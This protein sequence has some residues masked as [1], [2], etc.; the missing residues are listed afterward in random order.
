MLSMGYRRP[1]AT[2]SVTS[3]RPGE[4]MISERLDVEDVQRSHLKQVA[5]HQ[6]Q[7]LS[8]V[9]APVVGVVL[10]NEPRRGWRGPCARRPRSPS[11]S[12]RAGVPRA[13]RNCN[14]TINKTMQIKAAWR[15]R[16]GIKEEPRNSSDIGTSPGVTGPRR[17]VRNSRA[18]RGPHRRGRPAREPMLRGHG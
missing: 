5:A 4:T 9:A 11:R 7:Q 3:A 6:I 13:K 12:W 17:A 18:V 15:M 10:G 16:R 8:A 14:E 1:A 2:S